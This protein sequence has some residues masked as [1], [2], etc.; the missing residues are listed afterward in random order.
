M[1]KR[2]VVLVLAFALVAIPA[3]AADLFSGAPITN[4]V[5]D[6]QAEDGVDPTIVR[7]RYVNVN[8]ALISKAT[9]SI[10][11]NLFDDVVLTA[12]QASVEERRTGTTWVG[13][14]ADDARS[15]VVLTYE[16]GHLF[17]DVQAANRIYQVR[18]LRGTATHVVYEIRQSAFPEC[19]GEIE[20]P[21]DHTPTPPPAIA[22]DDG[23]R[24]DVMV[25]YTADVAAAS[26]DINAE[27][28]ATVAMA[29]ASYA[30]SGITTRVHLVYKG[31]V[32]YTETGNMNTD[33][34]RLRA[35][36]DGY[37][38]NVHTL[39]DQYCADQVSLWVETNVD[40]CGLA[41]LMTTVDTSFASNAFSVVQRGCAT[42]NH[43]FSHELGHNQSM[44]HDRYVDNANTPFT[45]NHG[46][47]FL[48]ELWRTIMAYNTECSAAGQY[49]A[50]LGYF[51]NPDNLYY[52]TP[53]GIAE[54][55]PAAA[56]N[57][58]TLNATDV[59]VA[60]FRDSALCQTPIELTSFTA[61]GGRSR[62]DV[63]WVTETEADNAGFHL[64]RADAEDGDYVRITT[65]LIPSQGDGTH[66]GT[67]AFADTNV[68]SGRTYWYKLEDVDV[69]GGSAFHGPVDATVL[70]EPAFGCGMT[71]DADG[72]LAGLLFLVGLVVA[73]RASRR[74]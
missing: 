12:V 68:T 39:R 18:P 50:R 64:W 5:R 8:A 59:T 22:A 11:L 38:D 58:K 53:M 42:G 31:Q 1:M 4:V 13:F 65:A 62:V 41:Y 3:L 20:P 2:S 16:N 55:D 49:C 70:R 73:M 36:A 28:V 25:V 29:N 47:V 52:G 40:S 23:S 67:Y 32:T 6:H 61:T 10:N 74:R 27:I 45:Y 17:G 66:G 37:M 44:R 33:L 7:G 9:E 14:L 24:I 30:A 43:S 54:G 35:T 60:N 57:R 34:A 72:T 63:A 69:Y 15:L 48:P 56:D 71:Y 21:A 51:S 26:P 46:Y 19:G